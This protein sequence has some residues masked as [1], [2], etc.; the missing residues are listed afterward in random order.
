MEGPVNA[1]EHTQGMIPRALQQ[2]FT[3]SRDLNEKGWVYKMEASFI[4]IYNETLHD[5]LAAGK[6]DLKHEIRIDPKNEGEVYVTNITPVLIT[7]E[8]QV[9]CLLDTAAKRRAVA[10]TESNERSS[11]SHCVF[12]LTLLGTNSK[13]LETCHGTLNLVDLAG[14]ERLVSNGSASER[15]KETQSINKSLSNLGNVI[16]A[17]ANQ[18]QHIP[19]RNSKL[20]YL[21]QNSLGGNSKTLMF[22]NISPQPSAVQET[23]SSLRFASKVNQ[24]HIGTAKTTTKQ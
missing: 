24:C 23:L 8:Q 6:R 22:V 17:L 3:S 18:E 4:E 2:V 12:R 10:A 14:S 20:T 9:S 1:D 11:R 7:S 16:M 13:T 5:L 21:L 15:L 19:Y